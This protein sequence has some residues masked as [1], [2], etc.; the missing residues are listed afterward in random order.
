MK[1]ASARTLNETSH[2]DRADTGTNAVMPAQSL[3]VTTPH[4]VWGLVISI[5]GP[6][7]YRPRPAMIVAVVRG[8]WPCDLPHAA[9]SLTPR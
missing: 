6:A 3:P 8:S 9:Y 7:G 2:P 4:Y 1:S 5:D